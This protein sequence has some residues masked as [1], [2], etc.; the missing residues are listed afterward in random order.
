MLP[1]KFALPAYTTVI[2]WLPLESVVRASVAF[3]LPKDLV[4]R[5]VA[6]SMN[7][8]FPVGVPEIAGVTVAVKVTEVPKVDGFNE[9]VT[10]VVLPAGFTVCV[11]TADVLP[12]KFEFPK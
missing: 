6:P 10:A 9:D 3:P 2:V 4:P 7:V 8:T 1:V 5:L 12:M 11:N